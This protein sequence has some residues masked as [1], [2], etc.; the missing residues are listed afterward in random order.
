MTKARVV[1]YMKE[2]KKIEREL[3][4]RLQPRDLVAHVYGHHDLHKK[5]K[6]KDCPLAEFFTWDKAKVIMEYHLF[7]ARNLL[8][9][10]YEYKV[11][12]T[13]GRRKL[14]KS[15]AYY[16][17]PLVN[18]DKDEGKRVY[19][20]AQ[21]VLVRG[22]Y[23]QDVQEDGIRALRAWCARYRICK[24]LKKLARLIEEEIEEIEAPKRRAEL[25]G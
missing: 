6:G 13:G 1:R 15:P 21:D 9:H 19:V 12:I 7:E 16:S 2:L 17:V 18:A 23:M 11:V 20:S 3:G 22:D 25:A 8:N 5:G 10:L 14:E 4:H 24:R